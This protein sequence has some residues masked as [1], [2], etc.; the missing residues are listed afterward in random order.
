MP[1]EERV[2]RRDQRAD[3]PDAKRHDPPADLEH[4]E[5]GER[6]DHD[7]RDPDDQPVAL[8]DPVEAGEE[9]RVERLRVRGR[10]VRQE[11]ERTAR[12]ERLREAVALL[13]ELREDRPALGEE[14]D[15]PRQHGRRDD[16]RV[17]GAPR[18]AA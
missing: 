10:A 2:Q 18:H 6:G 9:P 14:D 17:R 15:E 11:A 13:D 3:E 5:R 16:D 7:V 8:E 4:D 12:D 1:D